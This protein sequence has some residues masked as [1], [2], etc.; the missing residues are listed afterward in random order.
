MT[1]LS[2]LKMFSL[3]RLGGIWKALQR[4]SQ[5]HDGLSLEPEDMDDCHEA[6]QVQTCLCLSVC[7]SVKRRKPT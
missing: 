1:F 5:G 4:E 7:L 2:L 3:L 6:A